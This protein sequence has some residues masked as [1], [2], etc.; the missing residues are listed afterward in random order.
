MRRGLLCRG[1]INSI[2]SP[3]DERWVFIK[4]FR[5]NLHCARIGGDHADP[6]IRIEEELRPRRG[7]EGDFLPVRRPVRVAVRSWGAHHLFHGLVVHADD[8]QICRAKGIKSGSLCA[9]NA[10]RVP[11][12]DQEKSPTLNW[13]PSVSR[14]GS[15]APGLPLE[16][17]TVQRWVI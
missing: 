6:A 11:S 9:L 14:F 1:K 2:R 7:F 4:R 8:V 10:M 3:A 15:A 17:S 13:S 5:Q 16:N 12:A